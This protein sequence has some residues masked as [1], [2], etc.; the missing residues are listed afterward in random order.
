MTLRKRC[1]PCSIVGL[2]VLAAANCAH[3]A[4]PAAERSA[5]LDIY[6]GAGGAGWIYH[7]NWNGAVGSECGNDST[8]APPWFGVT[9]DASGSHVISIY[10]PQNNLVGS[11][12][13][14]ISAFSSLQTLNVSTN[15]LSGPIPT[16]AALT[17]LQNVSLEQNSFSGGLPALAGLGALV[18]FDA[19]NNSLSGPIPSLGGLANLQGFNISVNTLTGS[20]PALAGLAKL[21]VV[22]LHANALSGSLPSLA[23]LTALQVFYAQ[24][25]RFSGA[26]PALGGLSSLQFFNVD[27]NQLTGGIPAL[28]GLPLKN[29]DVGANQLTGALPYLGGLYTLN[30]L[31]VGGNQLTGVVPSPPS[32]GALFPGASV[33]CGNAFT[34]TANTFWDAATGVTPWYSACGLSLA[35]FNLDQHGLTGAWYNPAT[36]GQG[37][38]IESYKDL[39]GAGKGYLT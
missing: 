13:A 2:A 37:L 1:K 26:I 25:N 28:D 38:L 4:I 10:L 9:C 7:L 16:I 35:A 33:L 19:S 5:L 27:G 22:D 23:G 36:G 39:Q 21:Q 31:N 12:P 30:V 14:S 15:S 8:G 29:F 11:L 6:N 18:G 3:A 34:P 32:P 24:A 17:A 20:V